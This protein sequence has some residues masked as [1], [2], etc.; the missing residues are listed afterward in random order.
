MILSLSGFIAFYRVDNLR[1]SEMMYLGAA[2]VLQDSGVTR[3]A[4]LAQ[5]IK[6]LFQRLIMEDVSTV[7]KASEVFMRIF[8][9]EDHWLLKTT[10]KV[11]HLYNTLR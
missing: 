2:D 1:D 6:D 9:E 7:D 4:E 3:D 8:P 5:M 10:R 11:N